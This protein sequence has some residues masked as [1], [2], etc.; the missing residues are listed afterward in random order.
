MG[1][2]P[3]NCLPISI[4]SKTHLFARSRLFLLG[5]YTLITSFTSHT[6]TMTLSRYDQTHAHLLRS[7]QDPPS[8]S[9]EVSYECVSPSPSMVQPT[10]LGDSIPDGSQVS[11]NQLGDSARTRKSDLEQQDQNKDGYKPNSSDQAQ[12]LATYNE[13]WRKTFSRLPAP[14]EHSRRGAITG[15]S[16]ST[17][18]PPEQPKLPTD[19]VW[20]GIPDKYK[21]EM[22]AAT[23]P[24]DVEAIKEKYKGWD[25]DP[26]GHSRDGH[27]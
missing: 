5:L 20:L 4:I 9:V 11:I 3:S 24:A 25:Y 21:L 19:D 23:E 27:A 6:S 12:K 7:R 2:V 13:C 16:L 22:D 14:T 26:E 10:N 17:S 1:V 15:S 8:L 18:G